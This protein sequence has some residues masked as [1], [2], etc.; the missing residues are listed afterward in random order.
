MNPGSRLVENLKQIKTLL[1]DQR[2][3]AQGGADKIVLKAG[4]YELDETLFIN[5]NMVIEAAV[6][7]SV[8]FTGKGLVGDSLIRISSASSYSGDSYY[9]RRLLE[10]AEGGEAATLSNGR[11]VSM[12]ET[13]EEDEEKRR[14][15][16]STNPM[17]SLVGLTIT[18][19]GY[20]DIMHTGSGVQ[21]GCYYDCIRG[22]GIHINGGTVNV[23]TCDVHGNVAGHGGGIFVSDGVLTITDSTIRENVAYKGGG[24]SQEGLSVNT[25]IFGST[26]QGNE[27]KLPAARLEGGGIFVDGGTLTLTTT[28]LRDNIANVGNNIQP[29]SG[30]VYYVSSS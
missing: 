23:I 26:I 16:S 22:G 24:L 8:V 15:Q 29:I 11:E 21:Y 1:A 27:A 19:G 4:T 13:E 30:I 18:G 7:G 28:L 17:V 12:H 2:T 25:K 3:A 6:P 9:G 20:A 10:S 5:R 14:L